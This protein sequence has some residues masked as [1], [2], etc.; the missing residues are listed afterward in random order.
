MECGLLELDMEEEKETN[1]SFL[2]EALKVTSKLVGESV[3]IKIGGDL[4]SKPDSVK[5]LVEDIVLLKSLGINII[6]VHGGIDIANNFLDSFELKKRNGKIAGTT[7]DL[8]EMV[9]SGYI[10]KSIVNAI[11]LQGGSAIGISGKDA[12]LIEASKQR[13]IKSNSKIESILDLGYLGEIS[14]IN[15]E[16]LYS[17]EDTGLIPVISPIAFSE[18]GDTYHVSSDF[19]ALE[20]AK[21]Y[22]A[23]VLIYVTESEI[24]NPLSKIK[25]SDAYKMSDNPEYS[26][27]SNKIICCIRA[28]EDGIDKTYIVPGGKKNAI[29]QGVFTSDGGAKEIVSR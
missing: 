25:I 12:N 26:K 14:L 21:A 1:S 28:L 18:T 20:V 13:R 29:I 4:L 10:N 27:F 5:Y 6:I 11:N 24:D 23:S 3:V 7:I 2:A 22:S 19:V 16:I 17:L 8:I 9:M 15:P